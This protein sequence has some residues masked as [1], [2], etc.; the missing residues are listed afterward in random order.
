MRSVPR[1][2]AV[3][4]LLIHQIPEPLPNT[5]V[6]HE[7]W[8]ESYFFVLHPPS[9]EGDVII[10]TMATFPAREELDALQLGRVDGEFIYARH[11]RPYGDGRRSSGTSPT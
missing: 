7:H 1:L 9:G 3:D 8:R 2:T 6:H 4:E 10:L 5:A 11:S